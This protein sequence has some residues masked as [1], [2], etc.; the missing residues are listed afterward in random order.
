M[1]FLTFNLA[2]MNLSPS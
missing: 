2:N 1:R